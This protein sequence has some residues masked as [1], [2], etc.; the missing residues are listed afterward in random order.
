MFQ[1]FIKTEIIQ[2]ALCNRG[3]YSSGC[4][5]VCVPGVCVCVCV[6]IEKDRRWECE[7]MQHR[8]IR[9]QVTFCQHG[10]VVNL[11][12][13]HPLS[14]DLWLITC[15]I[16]PSPP[17]CCRHSPPHAQDSVNTFTSNPSALPLLLLPCLDA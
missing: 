7:R 2:S 1:R 12:T 10:F 4:R 3:L 6:G 16:L 14:F 9:M 11:V 8:Q 17:L 13:Q 15:C 5:C